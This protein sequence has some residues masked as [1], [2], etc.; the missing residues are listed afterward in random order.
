MATDHKRSLHELQEGVQ[1][2]GGQGFPHTS[3]MAALRARLGR[4]HTSDSTVE[5]PHLRGDGP[6]IDTE[7]QTERKRR[8][9]NTNII[10]LL[11]T[12]FC[13]KWYS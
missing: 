12:F 4:E 9:I 11:E 5:E 2:E 8:I 6:L 13:F 3:Q 10:L 1:V 7:R